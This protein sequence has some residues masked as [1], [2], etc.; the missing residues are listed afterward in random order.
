MLEARQLGLDLAERCAEKA[1]RVADFDT[2][3]ARRAALGLLARHGRMS[4]E[5]LTD[6]LKAL[7]FRGHD[8][9][10]FGSVYAVL[11]KRGQIKCV[12]YC[13]RVRGHG[14]AGGRYWELT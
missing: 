13:Q 12:G 9:R 1:S 8:D 2:E 10:C 11:S 6:E 7:G 14:A 4:G 5:S 3:G